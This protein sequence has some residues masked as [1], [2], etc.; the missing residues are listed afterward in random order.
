MTAGRA[1]VIALS[2]ALAASLTAAQPL[3]P[4][5]DLAYLGPITL[6]VDATDVEHKVLHVVETIPVRP[7]PLLLLYPQWIPGNHSPTGQVKRLAGLRIAA[8]GRTVPWTRDPEHPNAF[9]I[10]VPAGVSSLEL[11]FQHLMSLHDDG[12]SSVLTRK[13]GAVAFQGAVLYPAGHQVARIDVDASVRFPAG[14]KQAGALRPLGESDGWVKYERVSLETLVDSPVYAGRHL[15]RIDLDAGASRP[16]FLDVF[17]ADPGSLAA[18]EEQIDIHRNVVRQAD[19]LFGARHF[20]HFDMLLALGE[21]VTSLG[22][23]HQ[24]SS[25]NSAK[26]GYFTDWKAS[27]RGRYMIPHEFVHSW[28][29]KFRRPRDLWAGDFNAPTRNSLLWVY[30]GL[31]QY[32]GDV[33]AARSGMYN[34]EEARDRLAHDVA[35]LQSH[36]GRHWRSVQDTTYDP[37]TMGRQLSLDWGSW[38]RNEDYYLEGALIW[39]DADTR[40]RE[41][42]GGERSLDDFARAFFGVED[43][44]ITPLL[45]D[46][47]DVVGSLRRVQSFD[48]APLLKAQVE[49]INGA[50]PLDGLMRSGWRLV[51][52]DK[53]SEPAKAA[54][55][56]RE[57]A[58]FRYSIGIR[59]GKK[60]DIVQVMWESPAFRSGLSSGPMLLAVNL[61]EYKP[62]LLAAAITAAKESGEPLELLV[63][64]GREYRVIRLDYHGGLRYPALERI[65]GTKDWLTPIMSAR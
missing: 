53:Q 21:E 34:L 64:E 43:G 10:D 19:R 8:A 15:R 51:W 55:A 65:E 11:R 16:V 48:W 3:P 26:P 20:A 59:I 57:V 47:D 38:Q 6:Q 60:G 56:Y 39:L 50:A 58:D 1:W 28:N 61:Q 35:W 23:E 36:A 4:A 13:I 5:R 63:K 41:L 27:A 30:E 32:W 54:D 44:R 7:G 33:L 24:Q 12:Y 22:L 37:I 40:I 62:E 18:T 29:G 45:Y 52:S 9:R 25:E 46:L 42:S 14:W 17:A 31:T 2:A 49:G